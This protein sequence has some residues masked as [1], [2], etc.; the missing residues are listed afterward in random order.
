M[1]ALVM[2]SEASL[3]LRVCM[4]GVYKQCSVA[5]WTT[6]AVACQRFYGKQALPLYSILIIQF[7]AFAV[8]VSQNW[9]KCNAVMSH[10]IDSIHSKKFC[11]GVSAFGLFFDPVGLGGEMQNCVLSLPRNI[12]A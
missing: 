5:S 3:R 6:S 9:L 1:P 2:Q 8:N 4:L 7:W 12:V 11:V 10:V